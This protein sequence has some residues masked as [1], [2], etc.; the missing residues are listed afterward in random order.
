MGERRCR[1]EPAANSPR[2][3]GANYLF[4]TLIL[5]RH[6]SGMEITEARHARLARRLPARRGNSGLPSLRVPDAILRMAGHGCRW[7]ILPERFGNRHAID[8]R[9][10]RWSKNGV[11]GEVLEHPRRERI[12][13]A[14]IEAAS[15]ACIVAEVRP[16]GTG[17]R[18][19]VPTPS[20]SPAAAG[21]PKIHMVAEDARTVPAF[22]LSP[23]KRATTSACRA[24]TGAA[25][26]RRGRSRAIMA[27]DYQNILHIR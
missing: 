11:P 9:T 23:G 13:R 1:P 18:K 7:R 14:G 10:D 19:T 27:R 24:A 8:A 22:S 17:A 5:S 15:T 16:D 20:A 2:R 21:P 6:R 26:R 3:A 12:A 25:R 4:V